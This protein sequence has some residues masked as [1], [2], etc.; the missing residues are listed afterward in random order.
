MKERRERDWG[1]GRRKSKTL[2]EWYLAHSRLSASVSL[3]LW[4]VYRRCCP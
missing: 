3:R 1:E 4:T 2:A